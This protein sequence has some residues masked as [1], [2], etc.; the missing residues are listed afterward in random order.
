MD[1]SLSLDQLPETEVCAVCGVAK[2]Q[3][4][5]KERMVACRRRQVVVLDDFYRCPACGEEYYWPAQMDVVERRAREALAEQDAVRPERVR[6][7]RERLGLTQFQFEDLLG[8]GRNTVV[9]WESGQVTPNAATATLLR[10][11]EARPENVRLLAEWR[12]VRLPD[13]A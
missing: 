11:L 1:A 8:V 7:L 12:H 4:T 3:R 6:A 10:L 2:A 13:A 9:R 5:Q